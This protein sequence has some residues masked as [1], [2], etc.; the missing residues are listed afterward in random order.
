MDILFDGIGIDCSSQEFAARSLCSVMEGEKAIKVV[1][2]TY[3]LFSILGGVSC[4]IIEN[5]VKQKSLENSIKYSWLSK[6]N[7]TSMG[8]F[9]V[10]RGIKNIH[11]L[12]E[13][14][15][16]NDETEVDAWDGECNKILGT[17]STM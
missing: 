11:Q 1:N 4:V 13:V 12:G 7:A 5:I 10:Y 16:I 6:A 14:V 15:R 9:E 2:E 8:R 3:L 17:D